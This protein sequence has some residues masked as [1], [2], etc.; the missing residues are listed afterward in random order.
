MC[1]A[2]HHELLSSVKN[3]STKVDHDIIDSYKFTQNFCSKLPGASSQKTNI[4]RVLQYNSKNWNLFLSGTNRARKRCITERWLSGNL[5]QH[6]QR[7]NYLS[8]R[9]ARI[10]CFKKLSEQKRKGWHNLVNSFNSKTPTSQIWVLI[11]CF[12]RKVS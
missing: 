11:K 7:K 5:S 10:D 12:K 9:K 8:F 6:L 2:F 1:Q 3:L 4:S